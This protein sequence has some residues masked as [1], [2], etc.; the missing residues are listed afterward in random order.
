MVRLGSLNWQKR[1]KTEKEILFYFVWQVF[2]LY[3]LIGHISLINIFLLR[4]D[5]NQLLG[6]RINHKNVCLIFLSRKLMFL[7]ISILCKFNERMFFK[8]FKNKK[9]T[10]RKISNNKMRKL[11]FIISFLHKTQ[12]LKFFKKTP[13]LLLFI[14]DVS[15]ITFRL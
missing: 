10:N 13:D 9:V 1:R 6:K 4:T 14:K 5:A 12:V 11:I 3:G 8:I 2:R 15:K 7:L